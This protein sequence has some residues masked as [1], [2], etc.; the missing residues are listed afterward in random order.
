MKIERANLTER[1]YALK[2]RLATS[3]TVLMERRGCALELIDED[4]VRGCGESLPLPLS[5]TE[6]LDAT[7]AALRAASAGL[8]G[9]EGD[10]GELLNWVDAQH[11]GT[12]AARCAIDTALHDLEAQRRGEPVAS[13]L[14]DHPSR[15]VEVNAVLGSNDAGGSTRDA[16]ASVSRG[17]RTLK[18]K[19]GALPLKEEVA[20]LAA[21]RAAI[22]RQIAIRVDANGSWSVGAALSALERL[23]DFDLEL[24][25]QPV[26]ALDLEGLR[27]VSER[28]PIPVAADEALASDEGRRALVAGKLA[29]VAILKP[30]VL[31]GLRASARLARAAGGVGVRC[32]V[33]TTFEGPVG[34][35]AALHLAA[36]VGDSSLAH[37]LAASD[38]LVADFPDELVPVAGILR[39]SLR[40]G[41]LGVLSR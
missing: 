26:E 29:P 2:G 18:L 13:L 12:P 30:M 33:T 39:R 6:D 20:R 10:L 7:R 25:E 31:G 11:G 21:V 34:L 9:R 16:A 28:S 5:G 23:S 8:P 3:R 4:G 27:R 15:S 24:I 14:A 1:C 41:L 22:P 35:A 40:P 36:A 37:G 17:Y 32:V 19:V 38:V